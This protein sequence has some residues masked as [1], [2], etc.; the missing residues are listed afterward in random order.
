MKKILFVLT[1]N[2]KLGNTNKETGFYLPEVAHPY[3][4]LKN[5]FKIEKAATPLNTTT[6]FLFIYL[7]DFL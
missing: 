6:F 7:I 4:I 5:S 3:E 2:N 1:N